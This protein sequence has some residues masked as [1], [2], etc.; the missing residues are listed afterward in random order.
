MTNGDNTTDQTASEVVGQ[1]SMSQPTAADKPGKQ[2]HPKVS[3]EIK[4]IFIRNK[5]YPDAQAIFQFEPRP[6][7][8]IKDDAVIVL[9]TNTLLI[10]YEVGQASLDQIEE[11]YGRLVDQGRLVVPGQ[12]ARE[13]AVHRATKLSELYSQLY[14][15]HSSIEE[16]SIGRYPLLEGV[17][18]FKQT[19]ELVKNVNSQIRE[20]RK[21]L[22]EVVDHV[23]SWTWNDPVSLLYRKLFSANVV[24]DS[25]FDDDVIM[26]DLQRR[27]LY[28]LPPGYNDKGNPTSGIGDILIWHT[29]L[30]L[31]VKR[32]KSLIFVSGDVKSDWRVKSEKQSLYTRYEL[33]EEYRRVSD[34]QT[35]Q[36]IDLATLLDLFGATKEVLSEV[37]ESETRSITIQFPAGDIPWIPP[38]D[39]AQIATATWVENTQPD[40]RYIGEV[41]DDKNIVVLRQSDGTFTR[42]YIRIAY[43]PVHV[44][45]IKEL[46]VRAKGDLEAGVAN[47]FIVAAVCPSKNIADDLLAP[48]FSPTFNVPEGCIVVLGYLDAGQNFVARA[49]YQRRGGQQTL[50]I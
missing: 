13:F 29:I 48:F 25:K 28:N 12:V 35:F 41:A 17:T 33:V 23:R 32:K 45:T 16:L 8:E 49:T 43:A 36:C 38:L 22:A 46:I 1:N 21:Q 50:T 42:L 7:A 18:P 24:V 31:A 34:G 9:D 37:R 10:P 5:V 3:Q 15:K 11:T 39:V 47:R 6:L 26:A 40:V 14:K 44:E 20:Y 4:D 30:D 27:H 19:S 2:P